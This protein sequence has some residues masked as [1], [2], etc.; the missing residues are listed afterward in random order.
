MGTVSKSANVPYTAEQMYDLVNDIESYP[1][2]LP[3]CTEAEVFNRT[4]ESLIATVSLATGRLKQSFTTENTMQGGERIDVKLIK[5]PFKQLSG[6]WKFEN[7]VD[8]NCRIELNMD[9]EFKNRILKFT[10][11]A[12]FNQFMNSLVGSFSKRAK[13]VYSQV[14]T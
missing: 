13:Q 5:G 6:F 10:L 11:S 7:T 8:N 4:D 2:F 12:V 1:E 3:W 14:E 9:F